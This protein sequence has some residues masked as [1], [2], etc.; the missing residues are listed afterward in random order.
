MKFQ[1]CLFL[2]VLI[3]GCG[4]GA[5]RDV[6]V[7]ALGTAHAQQ[8]DAG[9]GKGQ[10]SVDFAISGTTVGANQD[11]CELTFTV[12][13]NTDEEVKNLYVEFAVSHA[14][15][16]AVVREDQ[17]VVVPG[18][19]QPGESKSPFGPSY[20][21]GLSCSDV[22]LK[23]RDLVQRHCRKDCSPFRYSASGIA[24]LL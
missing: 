24:G 14:G 6:P 5:S 8:A 23:P 19:I 12:S 15:T 10:G 9:P 16:G 3:V 13:N 2:A 1:A 17:P 18:R 22:R 4:D 7:E 20:V 21:S 11:Q